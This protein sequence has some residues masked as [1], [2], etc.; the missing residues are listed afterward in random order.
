MIH[1]Y[2]QELKRLA[3]DVYK[4]EKRNKELKARLKRQEEVDENTQDPP[5]K[6]EDKKLWDCLNKKLEGLKKNLKMY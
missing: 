6:T 5:P 2:K 3:T 1:M 4:W